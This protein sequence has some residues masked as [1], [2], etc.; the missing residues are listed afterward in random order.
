MCWNTYHCL[1]IR[2]PLC[3]LAVMK[4]TKTKSAKTADFAFAQLERSG[5]K[6]TKQRESVIKTLAASQ[7]AL[8]V[9][10]LLKHGCRGTC[11]TV[12][13]YRILSQFLASGLVHKIEIGDEKASRYE[14]LHNSRHHHHIVCTS[15]KSI[16]ILE[17][18][19]PPSITRKVSARGYKNITHTLEF[20]GVCKGCV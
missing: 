13:V 5:L 15:C 3:V 1:P 9:D 16:E 20:F 17:D 19:V 8:S 2:L 18:C 14:I 6:R 10:E 11:D 4:P 7:K 12:T